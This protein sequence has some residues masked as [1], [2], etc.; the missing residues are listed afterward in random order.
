MLVD[1]RSVHT[2]THSRTI[3]AVAVALI[4]CCQFELLSRKGRFFDL[5]GLDRSFLPGQHPRH[6]TVAAIR[7]TSH[8]PAAASSSRL[9]CRLGPRQYFPTVLLGSS[10]PNG[11]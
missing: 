9:P 7:F 5:Q 1:S 2:H 8:P 6:V 11:F 3:P 4:H 10:L